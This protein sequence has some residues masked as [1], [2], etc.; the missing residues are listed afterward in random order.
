MLN[1][2]WDRKIRLFCAVKDSILVKT[3][4]SKI[5]LTLDSEE[6][7]LQLFTSV[8]IN[9]RLWFSLVGYTPVEVGRFIVSSSQCTV[10]NIRRVLQQF[11]RTWIKIMRF[12]M[13]VISSSTS[14]RVTTYRSKAKEMSGE[15]HLFRK[16]KWFRWTVGNF[17]ASLGPTEAKCSLRTLAILLGS[18]VN[19]CH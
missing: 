19:C 2:Y 8:F 10:Y 16:W 14:A 18:L 17:L 12:D 13:W 7:G 9:H 15:L 1:A 11:C 3:N 5:L 4:F 6:I